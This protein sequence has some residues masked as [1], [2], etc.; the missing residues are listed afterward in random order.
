M[1]SFLVNSNLNFIRGKITHCEGLID[2]PLSDTCTV[3][4]GEVSDETHQK[5]ADLLS[6]EL[7]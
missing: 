2:F 4:E 1:K 3:A 5:K 7:L 6:Y